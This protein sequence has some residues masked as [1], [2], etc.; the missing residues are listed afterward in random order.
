MPFLD[1]NG[2]PYKYVSVRTDITAIKRSEK[3]AHAAETRLI[4][5]QHTLASLATSTSFVSTKENNFFKTITQRAVDTL[6]VSRVSIWMF[7]KSHKSITCRVLYDRKSRQWSDGSVLLKKN[8]PK[9]FAEL[10]Q[11]K[12]IVASSAHTDAAI[13]E[14]ADDYLN[15][16]GIGAMLHAPIRRQAKYIGVICCEHVGGQRMWRSD[17]QSFVSG[18]ADLVALNIEADERK[19]VEVALIAA[20]E[21]AETANRAKSEFLSSMSHELRTPMNAIIGFAQLLKLDPVNNLNDNQGENV[22]EILKASTHLLELINEVLDLARIEAGRVGL[23]IES[24]NYHEV[25]IECFNL[26]SELA[27]KRGIKSYYQIEGK[28]V[29]LNDIA[30]TNIFLHVDRIR[31]KQ[32][33]LNLLSNAVKY[34]LEGGSITTSCNKVDGHSVRISVSD[35]GKGITKEQQEDLFKSFNRLGKENSEIEGTGIG[36]VI[37]KNIVELMGGKIGI[38]SEAGKGS[39]FWV[40]FPVGEGNEL[41]QDVNKDSSET[42]LPENELDIVSTVLY[43][44]DNPANLRLVAQVLS[45][46][47]NVN[48]LSAHEPVLGMELASSR[49]P[50]LILLDI[51][52][53]GIDGYEVLKQLRMRKETRNIPVYAISANAMPKDI[54]RGME[55]GFDEYI[56][57]PINISTFLD[58]V[59]K[60]LN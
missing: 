13:A 50:D 9:Y 24:V 55:A 25:A 4:E 35:T 2:L 21:E 32:V 1:E 14:F 56:T 34:N 45:H 58:A 41:K 12:I 7:N 43:I 3:E 60:V 16:L 49:K 51:N 5:Q 8:Y 28:N 6:N 36:L 47:E 37:T 30:K 20:K 11:N 33:L 10:E 15:H 38:E 42:V 44:E 27:E 40:E 59:M 29:E 48:L 17:E 57:K 52:L 23:S 46:Q 18:L 39:T 26:V 31:F 22:D 54:E 53:P 19:A